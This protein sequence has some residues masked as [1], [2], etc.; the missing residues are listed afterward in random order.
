M[1]KTKRAHRIAFTISSL[2]SFSMMLILIPTSMVYVLEPLALQGLDC[3]A[4]EG[5]ES[6]EACAPE[7]FG[8]LIGFFVPVIS[9]C[10]LGWFLLRPLFRDHNLHLKPRPYFVAIL[11]AFIVFTVSFFFIYNAEQFVNDP[12]RNI[13]FKPDANDTNLSEPCFDDRV[14]G[15]VPLPVSF[16]VIPL[17]SAMS[18]FVV[19][20]YRYPGLDK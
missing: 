10:I 6:F 1:L 14:P 17:V 9:G 8:Q 16:F 13:Q 19:T 5:T 7:L 11:F 18:T 20:L 3:F 4:I 2:T 15:I 12:C